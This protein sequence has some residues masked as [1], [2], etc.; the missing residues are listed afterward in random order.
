M[1]FTL[2][3][4]EGVISGVNDSYRGS[5]QRV[6]TGGAGG[7]GENV[8]GTGGGTGSGGQAA[9]G[10]GTGTGGNTG[11]GNTGGGITNT[12]GGA[13]GGAGGG[14]S[15]TG[16][17]LVQP[18]GAWSHE[19]AGATVL[20][21]C[22]MDSMNCGGQMKNYSGNGGGIVQMPD[23]PFSPGGVYY[24]HLPANTAYGDGTQL[25]YT[26][27]GAGISEMYVG[28]YWKMNADFQGG[29]FANKLFFVRTF[30]N[31][32][33][34]EPVNGV[35]V[36][37]NGRD[38]Q[39]NWVPF[40]LNFSHN[41]GGGRLD[42]SHVC[43]AD[44]GL[45]CRPNVNDVPIE[46]DRWYLIEAYV[47][48]STC[49]TCRDAT[50]RWWVNGELVGDY[51]N[52]NYGSGV[53]NEFVFDHTWDGYENIQCQNRDCSKEWYHYLDHVHLSTRG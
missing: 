31:P 27:P 1:A 32:A 49:M 15:G 19:P 22:P 30:E 52:L 24:N 51:T 21:D 20:L 4:C 35:F 12:G 36:L 17:G 29:A 10:G 34:G 2:V 14:T 47:K 33:G 41:T 46:R 48:S 28:F 23:A 5:M 40:H 7:G 18:T 53:V 38:E 13:G 50:V 3:G 25:T 45:T 6:S 39:G 37:S 42:N 9:T 44:M 11:G 16:G 26:K 8:T 43:D